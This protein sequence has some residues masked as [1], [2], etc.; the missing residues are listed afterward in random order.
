MKGSIVAN[1]RT[2]IYV[3]SIV[4]KASKSLKDDRNICH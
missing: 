2:T 3:A 1:S 4:D